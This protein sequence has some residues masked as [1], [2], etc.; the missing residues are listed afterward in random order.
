MESSADKLN[1]PWKD[2]NWV[3]LLVNVHNFAKQIK[4]DLELFLIDSYSFCL[5]NS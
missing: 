1:G 4:E 5:K 3:K 2:V